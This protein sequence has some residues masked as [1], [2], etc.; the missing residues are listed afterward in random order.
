[1]P[2]YDVEVRRGERVLHSS[3]RTDLTDLDRAWQLVSSLSKTWDVPGARILVRDERGDVVIS[4]G[5]ATARRTL[6]A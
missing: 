6:A 3:T 1:M 4:I 5:V 2:S